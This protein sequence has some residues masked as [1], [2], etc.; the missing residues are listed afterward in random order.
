[1]CAHAWLSAVTHFSDFTLPTPI[2]EDSIMAMMGQFKE[3]AVIDPKCDSAVT[4]TLN[5][6]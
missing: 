2:T 6:S 3:Y 5:N 1:M 4:D